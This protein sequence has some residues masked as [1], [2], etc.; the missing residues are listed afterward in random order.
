M[1]F[2]TVFDKFIRKFEKKP[3]IYHKKPVIINFSP[4][5]N[6]KL[7]VVWMGLLSEEDNIDLLIDTWIK[8]ILNWTFGVFV[9][10]LFIQI[11]LI[12]FFSYTL[13]WMIILNIF[14]LGIGAFVVSRVWNGV[15]D[16]FCRFARSFPKK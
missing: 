9:S 2:S 6:L 11:A 4:K 16:G 12:P 8:D 1:T 7:F 3:R 14:A 13:S 10:G 5:H 15:I